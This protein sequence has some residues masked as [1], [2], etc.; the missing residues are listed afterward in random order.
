MVTQSVMVLP[1]VNVSYTNNTYLSLKKLLLISQILHRPK[2]P[3]TLS[4]SMLFFIK[5]KVRPILTWTFTGHISV[6]HFIKVSTTK[7]N[8]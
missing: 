3:F 1:S 5:D 2:L 7:N 8:V 4:E 6:L